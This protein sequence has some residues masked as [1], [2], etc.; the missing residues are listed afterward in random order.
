MTKIKLFEVFAFLL[1]ASVRFM[2]RS[3]MIRSKTSQ[4]D[5]PSAP[6]GHFSVINW[7]ELGTDSHTERGMAR[8]W[9]GEESRSQGQNVQEGN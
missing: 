3:S 8:G 5:C 2:T 4:L 9:Q 6:R 7:Q 1:S